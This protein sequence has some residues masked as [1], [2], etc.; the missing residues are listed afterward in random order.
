MS[1]YLWSGLMAGILLSL[2][3]LAVAGGQTY[4]WEHRVLAWFAGQ[5]TPLRD[6]FFI[7]VTWLGSF[8]LMGPAALGASLVLA[9]RGLQPSA[10]VLAAGFYGATVLTFLLKRLVGRARPDGIDP[11][12]YAS[13]ADGAFP[14]GHTSHAVAWALGLWWLARQHRRRWQWPVAALLGGFALLV[15][16]SRLYLQVHWPTDVAG[17]ALLS[18]AWCAAVFGSAHRRGTGQPS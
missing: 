14:S 11:A 5:R 8:Y 1:R 4:G 2:L 7:G 10:W 18:I 15:A 3:A 16:A 17:G 13:P 12:L 6:W 9:R